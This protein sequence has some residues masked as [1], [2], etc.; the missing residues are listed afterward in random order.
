MGRRG[1]TKHL[2]RI[3]A[4]KHWMLDKLGGVFAPKPSPGPHKTRECLPLILIVRNRLKYAL[5][6]R[7]AKAILMERF[8]KVDG[9]VRTDVCYP[10]GFMD[11]VS[12]EKT[13]EFFRLLYDTKGRMTVH[14][15]SAEES[16]YKLCKV[17]DVKIGEKAIPHIVT[18]DGRTIRY[19]DPLIKTNDTILFDIESGKI[20]DFVKFD[21]GNMCM[22]TGGRN[23][24][25]VGVI[26]SRE[27]HKGGNDIVHV[28]DS[29]G[30]SFA[31]RITNVFVIGKGNK[32][33]ISL[34]KGKGIKLSILQEQEKR[35]AA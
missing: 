15:I 25:R 3:N 34:P 9:K 5:T 26:V 32:P 6:G 23:A 13:D 14:R 27:K 18:H 16:S 21:T 33:L 11:V 24:G 22:V 19:A 28:K 17:R 10:A 2:K 12:L 31:T 1:P 30:A 4:P 20:R 29:S 7:E 8:V 35:Y